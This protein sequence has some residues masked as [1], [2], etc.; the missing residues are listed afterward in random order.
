M[1]SPRKPIF[2][3]FRRIMVGVTI[4]RVERSATLGYEPLAPLGH[5]TFQVALSVVLPRIFTDRVCGFLPR[6]FTELGTDYHRFFSW[7]W[8]V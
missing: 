2:A 4:P 8:D 3:S 5:S 7:V 1:L 6:I